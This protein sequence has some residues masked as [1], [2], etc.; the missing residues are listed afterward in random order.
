MLLK[1]IW[2]DSICG[3]LLK[4]V[5]ILAGRLDLAKPLLKNHYKMS[6]F[7]PNLNPKKNRCTLL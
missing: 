1:V 6:I 3:K 7:D 5:G 4:T 2:I